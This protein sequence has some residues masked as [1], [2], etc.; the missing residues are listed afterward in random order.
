MTL[1][2]QPLIYAEKLHRKIHNS[3]A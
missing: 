1:L 3:K 2:V